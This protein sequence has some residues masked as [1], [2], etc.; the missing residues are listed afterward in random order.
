MSGNVSVVGVWRG[1]DRSFLGANFKICEGGA[2]LSLFALLCPTPLDRLVPHSAATSIREVPSATQA[3]NLLPRTSWYINHL[4]SQ[5][6][7]LL[8]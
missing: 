5:F 8:C 1:G 3:L 4:A 7:G 2:H 6:A